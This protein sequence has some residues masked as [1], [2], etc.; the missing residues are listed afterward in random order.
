VYKK[1]KGANRIKIEEVKKWHSNSNEKKRQRKWREKVKVVMCS[2]SLVL[3]FKKEIQNFESKRTFQFCIQKIKISAY[4][5]LNFMIVS[6]TDIA[7]FN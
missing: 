4:S 2:L 5:I 7:S 6:A 3:H 1:Q